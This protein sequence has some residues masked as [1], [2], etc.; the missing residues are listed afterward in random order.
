[1]VSTAS[2]SAERTVLSLVPVETPRA[3]LNHLRKRYADSENLDLGGVPAWYRQ[4]VVRRIDAL[5][6]A[7]DRAV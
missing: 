6:L 4:A 7:R 5:L 1:M 3:K 2:I